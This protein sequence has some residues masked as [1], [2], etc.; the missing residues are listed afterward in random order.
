MVKSVGMVKL[1]PQN[2]T[3]HA[4]DVPSIAV[5][6]IL[7]YSSLAVDAA[8]RGYPVTVSTDAGLALMYNY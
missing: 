2:H 7:V 4:R 1:C 8:S 3:P 6:S 5:L